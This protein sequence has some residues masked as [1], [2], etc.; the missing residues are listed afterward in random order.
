MKINSNYAEKFAKK[1]F[2]TKLH[3]LERDFIIIHSKGVFDTSLKLAK[4]KMIDK[5]ALKI[6][7][8]LHDIGRTV[9]IAKHA[10]ISLEISEKKFGKLNDKIRDCILNHGSSKKPK[11]SEGKIFQLADKLSIVNDYKLFELLFSN[12]K[13][14][15]KSTLFIEMV[16]KDLSKVLRRYKW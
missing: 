8:W 10:E 2:K 12:P 1:I 7:A 9:D 15:K 4:N 3:G 16:S 11:T 13:Y 14:K 5:E 6:A